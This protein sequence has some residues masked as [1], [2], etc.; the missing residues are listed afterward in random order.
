MLCACLHFL[1]L[2]STS[3]LLFNTSFSATVS[4]G[5][6]APF[7]TLLSA[8]MVVIECVAQQVNVPGTAFANALAAFVNLIMIANDVVPQ[9][10][11]SD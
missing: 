2:S 8:P 9:R 7:A 11:E 6:S 3:F 4:T 1:P 10:C 5:T